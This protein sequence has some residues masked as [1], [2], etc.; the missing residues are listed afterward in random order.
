MTIKTTGYQWYWEYEYP[1]HEFNYTSF[2]IGQGSNYVT[3]EIR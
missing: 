3:E 1:D 2:M